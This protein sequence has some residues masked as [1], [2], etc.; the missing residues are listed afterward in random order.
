MWLLDADRIKAYLRMML[1][2][3]SYLTSTLVSGQLYASAALTL[4]KGVPIKEEDG[5]VLDPAWRLYRQKYLLHLLGIEL[6]FLG[7]TSL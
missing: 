6:I 7:F 1:Q 3:H 4:R 5:C 2:L